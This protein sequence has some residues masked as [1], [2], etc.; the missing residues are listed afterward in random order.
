MLS[1]GIQIGNMTCVLSYLLVPR[2]PRNGHHG[3]G[4]NAPRLAHILLLM[5]HKS[6][7]ILAIPQLECSFSNKKLAAINTAAQPC[8]QRTKHGT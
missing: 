2:I 7:E 5:K 6:S 1:R 3:A 8:H 4:Q